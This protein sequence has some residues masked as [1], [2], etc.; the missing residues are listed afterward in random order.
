MVCP[1][2]ILAVENIM[3]ELGI[4]ILSIDL[5]HVIILIPESFK[6]SIIE[7]KL[8]QLGFELIQE[9][10]DVLIEKIKVSVMEYLRLLEFDQEI[11]VLSDFLTK[12]IGKNYN[13]LTKIFSQHCNMTIEQYYIK[14]RLQ[15]VKQL[16][17]EG[18]L[19]VTEISYKLHYSS[20]NYLSAQFKKHIGISI[21][22]YK[23]QIDELKTVNKEISNCIN[24]LK[25]Q[26]IESRFIRKD[27]IYYCKEK[28][29]SYSDKDVNID[30]KFVHSFIKYPSRKARVSVINTIDKT[31]GILLEMPEQSLNYSKV[32]L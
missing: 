1:R 23:S 17:D 20:V 26:G 6:M 28:G 5:G 15:R 22:E 11:H 8:E 2:C 30:V 27:G 12:H 10:D 14:Q 4:K 24:D 21:S 29:I 31:K 25:I 16:L 19:N 7:D 32:I 9:R 3:D 18:K 13:Y